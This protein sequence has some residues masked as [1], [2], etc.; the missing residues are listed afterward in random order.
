M[1][2]RKNLITMAIV[3]LGLLMFVPF[4]QAEEK[5]IPIKDFKDVVGKWE[6]KLV[7]TAGWSTRMTIIINEDGTGDSFVSE[8]S[9]FFVYS[10]KGR[11]RMERKLVE[12]KIRNKNLVSGA[13]G[14]TTLHEEGGKRLLKTVTDDGTQSGMFEPAK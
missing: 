5:V 14:T 9:P 3:I 1:F 12:G 4:A 7:S 11:F 8:D 10:D 6:G 2:Y 13:T